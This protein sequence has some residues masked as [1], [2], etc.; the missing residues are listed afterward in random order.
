MR[1]SFVKHSISG[2]GSCPRLDSK[3]LWIVGLAGAIAEACL[4]GRAFGASG[5]ATRAY[6]A[7][8]VIPSEV[9]R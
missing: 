8:F 5:I 2:R 4:L 6:A 7:L 9:A 1:V 3:I